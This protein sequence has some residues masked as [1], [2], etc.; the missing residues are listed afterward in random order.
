MWI[1]KT[2]S[3]VIRYLSQLIL[4][5]VCAVVVLWSLLLTGC[6]YHCGIFFS[7]YGITIGTEKINYQLLD[8][9]TVID[10]KTEQGQLVQRTIINHHTE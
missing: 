10:I 8:N 9:Q 2:K 5:V 3:F 6:D 4:K 1:R 7:P